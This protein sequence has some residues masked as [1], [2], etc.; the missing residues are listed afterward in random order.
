MKNVDLKNESNNANTMLANRCFWDDLDRHFR[1]TQKFL[2]WMID[3]QFQHGISP[4]RFPN[5]TPE[6]VEEIYNVDFGD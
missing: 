5:L 6:R 2:Q 1:R 3:G 4:M